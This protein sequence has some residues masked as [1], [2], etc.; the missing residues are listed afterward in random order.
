MRWNSR[1]QPVIGCALVLGAVLLL[2]PGSRARRLQAAWLQTT[3]ADHSPERRPRALPEFFV[4][5]DPSHGGD[6]RGAALA[7]KL[8]EKDVTLAL[9]R[10]LRKEL[11]ERG[12][13][14]SL[15]RESDVNLSLERRADLTNEEHASIYIALHAGLPGKGARVYAPALLL[16][17]PRPAGP[18]LP[19][20]SAQ[21]GALERSRVV[22]Q[23]VA[24]ELRKT[25][26]PV[27][28][29]TMPLR[30]LNN[31]VVPAIAVEWAPGPEELRPAQIQ[32]L[33][34]ALASAIAAGIVQVRGQMRGRP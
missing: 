32:R 23:A 4:M 27:A 15:L 19:W 24:G 14:A 2:L 16:A 28:R 30:P 29:M 31:L 3:S 5:I 18:F 17:Q 25:G 9:A 11:A 26:L 13:A 34:S 1:V 10:E 33:E 6:D 8:L 21:A 22:A 7:G 20:E 12:I